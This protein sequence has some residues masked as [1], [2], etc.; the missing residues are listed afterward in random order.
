MGEQRFAEAIQ[1]AAV[2]T[3]FATY[4]LEAYFNGQKLDEFGTKFDFN[5]MKHIEWMEFYVA[6]L[7]T[8]SWDLFPSNLAVEIEIENRFRKQYQWVEKK[9]AEEMCKTLRMFL[10]TLN[11]ADRNIENGPTSQT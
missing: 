4:Q 5:T 3:C 6:K 8:G 1:N 11:R 7:K 10:L 2:K 9:E